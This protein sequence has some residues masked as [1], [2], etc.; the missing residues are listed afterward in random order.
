MDTDK[1]GSE[2]VTSIE[3]KMKQELDALRNEIAKMRNRM[4]WY[5]SELKKVR[6]ES[7]ELRG[8]AQA[9]FNKAEQMMHNLQIV[10]KKLGS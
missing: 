10:D 4:D 9:A 8:K 1:E 7:A 6:A 2:A 3:T 5:E